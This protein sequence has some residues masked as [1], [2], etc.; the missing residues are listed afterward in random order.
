[1]LESE[2]IAGLY[3]NQ[4]LTPLPCS[5]GISL[6]KVIAL[7]CVGLISYWIAYLSETQ[8]EFDE[9]KLRFKYML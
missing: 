9:P 7:Y 5:N 6:D 3:K 8:L 1:M 4:I 2:L